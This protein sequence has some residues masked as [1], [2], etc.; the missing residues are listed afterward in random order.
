MSVC[1]DVLGGNTAGSTLLMLACTGDADAGVDCTTVIVEGVVGEEL[2]QRA[3]TRPST[4][5]S[6]RRPGARRMRNSFKYGCGRRQARCKFT[7]RSPRL[8]ISDNHLKTG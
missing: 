4:A 8:G 6:A 7:A 3:A 5:M 2:P 1:V